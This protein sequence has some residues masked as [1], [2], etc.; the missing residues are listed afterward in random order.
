MNARITAEDQVKT[1]AGQIWV[2]ALANC[3]PWQDS[4]RLRDR[5]DSA[6]A[7]VSQLHLNRQQDGE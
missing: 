2:V 5:I 6:T 4:R 7:G 3:E 1:Y